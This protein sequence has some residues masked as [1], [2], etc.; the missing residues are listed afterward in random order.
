MTHAYFA[1]TDKVT[2]DIDPLEEQIIRTGSVTWTGGGTSLTHDVA[3]AL[4]TDHVICSF[5]TLPT[6]TSTVSGKVT[7]NGTLTFTLTAAN[8]SNNAIISYIVIRRN[9]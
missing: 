8:T 3:P 9:V 6:E 2:K 5:D 4:T 1:R 7:S